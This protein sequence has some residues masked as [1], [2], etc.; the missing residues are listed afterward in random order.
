M[1]YKT[2]TEYLD[3]KIVGNSEYK[4]QDQLLPL[5]YDAAIHDCRNF[6]ES[7]V[8]FGKLKVLIDFKYITSCTLI[9]A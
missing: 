4:R 9:C 8:K 6:N 2:A 1:A 3:Q 7:I 5:K